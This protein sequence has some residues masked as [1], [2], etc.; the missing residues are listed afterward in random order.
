MSNLK[1]YHLS[2]STFDDKGEVVILNQDFVSFDDIKEFLKTFDNT[3]SAP[4]PG[5]G[6]CFV[7]IPLCPDCKVMAN[8]ANF[9]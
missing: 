7:A 6:E 4:C 8:N 9:M 5:C 3:Q 1:K 2:F